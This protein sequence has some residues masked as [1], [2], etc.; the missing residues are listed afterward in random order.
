MLV[1]VGC[2]LIV[3]LPILGQYTVL[4]L[5]ISIGEIYCSI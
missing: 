4:N 5:P 3:L 1:E 2:L